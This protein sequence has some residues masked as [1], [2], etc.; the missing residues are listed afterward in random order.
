MTDNKLTDNEIIKALEC[1]ATQF[2]SGCAKKECP[3]INECQTDLKAVERFALSLINRQKAE[4]EALEKNVDDAEA[5]IEAVKRRCDV[6][7]SLM[8]R[9]EER[10]KAEAIK[11]FAE[12]LKAIY[13]EWLYGHRIDDLVKEMVGDD[14]G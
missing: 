4:I 2:P 10:I 12:R 6:A 7:L 9:K 13:G 5:E 8:E 14:N 3:M 11:E 1:C